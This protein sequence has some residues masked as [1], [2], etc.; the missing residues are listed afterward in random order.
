MAKK[1]SPASP[2]STAGAKTAQRAPNE[3]GPLHIRPN[4]GGFLGTILADLNDAW[5]GITGHVHAAIC[6]LAVVSIYVGMPKMRIENGS[7]DSCDPITTY[8]EITAQG[9]RSLV[10]LSGGPGGLFVDVGSGRGHFALW[11]GSEEGGFNRSTGIELQ[12]DRHEKAMEE[13]KQAGSPENI[14][15]VQGDVLQHL[16]VFADARVVYWNNLCFPGEIGQTILQSF[17]RRAAFGGKLFALGKV[18]P[19]GATAAAYGQ[20]AEE[21]EA[22]WLLDLGLRLEQPEDTIEV[23]WRKEGYKPYIYTRVEAS[24]KTAAAK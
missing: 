24:E 13:H 8:G 6:F 16:D 18:L 14:V 23:S 17:G 11:A 10:S 3:M 21:A 12:L 22:P 19:V 20:S 1:S 7:Q 4:K 2:V 5:P 15:F 9:M